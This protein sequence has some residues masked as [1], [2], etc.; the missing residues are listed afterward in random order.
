MFK[1]K[2]WNIEEMTGYTP[3][4]TFYEDLSIADHYGKDA[5]ID[6]YKRVFKYWSK[7]V[8]YITEFTM[9]L[10]W[11]IWEHYE[12][13]ESLARVY[14]ELWRKADAWCCKNLKDDDLSYYLRTTD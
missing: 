2:N 5:I 7:D 4:T 13:N 14:D 8:R 10:N 1:I 11:K 6:T 9:A 12:H 3:I